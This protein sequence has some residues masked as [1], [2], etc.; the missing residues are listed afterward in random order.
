M[1]KLFFIIAFAILGVMNV[2]AQETSKQKLDS[3]ITVGAG[4]TKYI[5]QYDSVGNTTLLIQLGWIDSESQWL[6]YQKKEYTYDANNNQISYIYSTRNADHTQWEDNSKTEYTYDANGRLILGITSFWDR[7]QSQWISHA[8][9]E[10][11]YDV[12]NNL[13]LII[14]SDWVSQYGTKTE[15]TYD[16]NNNKTSYTFSLCNYAQSQCTIDSK[17]EY[18]YDENNICTSLITSIW[19][20]FNSQLVI[21][22]KTEYIY[23][24]NNNRIFS[25]SFYWDETQSQWDVNGRNEMT[26]DESVSA[27][28]FVYNQEFFDNKYFS[29]GLVYSVLFSK[30][31]Q[32]KLRSLNNGV[33]REG[34]VYNFYWSDAQAGLNDVAATTNINIFPNPASD[35]LYIEGDGYDKVIIYD[36]LGKEVLTT[37]NKKEID[38]SHLP[39]GVYNVSILS[40]G[41]TITTKKIVKE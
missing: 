39:N 33:W 23:D 38:I 26:Y 29:V 7:N 41:K 25:V 3:I 1:K 35:K 4:A 17:E 31:L 10:Y 24:E 34:L 40:D 2:K 36:I 27:S 20:N 18:A 14:D 11:T 16:A 12:N 30:I 28:D 37:N 15:Y 19:D 8:K 21:Y 13:T 32:I 5:F 9:Q 22:S 6:S